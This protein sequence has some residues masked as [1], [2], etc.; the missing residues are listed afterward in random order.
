MQRFPNFL[1]HL[2][3]PVVVVLLIVGLLQ[4]ALAQNSSLGQDATHPGDVTTEPSK[5]A[6]QPP[7]GSPEQKITPLAN[8]SALVIGP[9][10]EVEITV[11]GAPDLSGKTRVSGD[12]NISMPLIDYVRIAGLSSSEAEAAIA[13]KLRE[14]NILNDPHV[15]VYVKEY[16]SSG[17]SVAGEV[18][19]PGVYSALGPHRLFDIL[20]TAGGLSERASGS[21]SISHKGNEEEPVTVEVSKDPA[22][23][24]R[25]N[26]E[27]HPG[28]TVFAAKAAMVYVLGEVMKPGGYILNSTGA[29][30]L[31]QVMAAAGGPTHS[32]AVGRA[33]MLR[34]TPSGLQEL[35]VPLKALLRGKTADIPVL[36][37][38]ILFV[39]SSRTKAFVTASSMVASTT[40]TAAIYRVF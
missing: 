7:V 35:P 34:R 13:A 20:Q 33:R 1:S 18:T 19:R 29:V 11:Y 12:G 6:A 32:A 37:E 38:D 23:M 27:L 26:V 17:I 28:D 5:I 36:A 10:D 30:T 15:S 21:V 22:E 2:S 14:N 9:G 16:N 31:L 8:S 4:V 40:A 24:V 3:N 25:S 39:P